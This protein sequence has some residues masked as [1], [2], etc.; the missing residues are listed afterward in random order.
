ML[1][2]VDGEMLGEAPARFEVLP[3]A[4]TVAIQNGSSS[5]N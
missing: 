5:G 4:L 2:Q 3:V 1:V